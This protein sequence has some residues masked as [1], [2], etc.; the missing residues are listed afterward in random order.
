MM[1]NLNLLPGASPQEDGSKSSSSQCTTPLTTVDRLRWL[2]EYWSGNKLTLPTGKKGAN[3]T[4]L[5]RLEEKILLMIGQT[6]PEW[7]RTIN[8]YSFN[9]ISPMTSL[10]LTDS[11]QMTSDSQHLG[12]YLNVDRQK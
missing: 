6:G 10:V 3:E 8:R 5:L 1:V 9:Y 11:S 12:I 7:G 2:G 4:Y